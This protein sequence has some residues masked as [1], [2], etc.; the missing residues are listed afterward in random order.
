MKSGRKITVKVGDNDPN[1]NI[2]SRD[3]LM[4]SIIDQ[5]GL[6]IVKVYPN[7]DPVASAR[8]AVFLNGEKLWDGPMAQQFGTYHM[9][10]DV[11]DTC[12]DRMEERGDLNV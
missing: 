7:Q 9:R 6:L 4:L 11:L 5:T 8:V 3:G 2:N 1:H 10:D 12:I